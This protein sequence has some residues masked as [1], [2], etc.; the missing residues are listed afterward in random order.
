MGGL[1]LVSAVAATTGPTGAIDLAF[2]RDSRFLYVVNAALG[3]VTAFAVTEGNLTQIGSVGGLPTS[4]QGIV[5][6]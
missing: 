6:R 2:S 1:P 3:T 4:V 5:A